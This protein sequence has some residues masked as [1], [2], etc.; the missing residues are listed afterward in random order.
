[1]HAPTHTPPWLHW[2]IFYYWITMRKR[3]IQYILTLY[4]S[5]RIYP[6]YVVIVCNPY[7]SGIYCTTV[8]LVRFFSSLALLYCHKGQRNWRP[9]HTNIS[10]ARGL[11][12]TNK[13][14]SKNH[15]KYS[16]TKFW[17]ESSPMC[18]FSFVQIEKKIKD[19][20]CSAI[21][22]KALLLCRRRRRRRRP[23]FSEIY[24]HFSHWKW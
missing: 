14:K 1:M 12:A 8:A 22:L 5:A 15:I 7:H 24:L 17:A 4:R 23:L 20:L 13:I 21:K 11:F 19:R 6:T 10:R 16:H 3:L 18:F 9:V 2:F